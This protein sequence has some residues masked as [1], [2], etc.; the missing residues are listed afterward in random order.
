MSKI[1]PSLKFT[2][3]SAFCESERAGKGRNGKEKKCLQTLTLA[4][5]CKV[6][7]LI[8]SASTISVT[9]LSHFTSFLEAF[10]VISSGLLFG[11]NWLIL[12]ALLAP[13]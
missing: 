5:G 10:R 12:S 9:R 3:I 1:F 4:E 13:L 7:Q 6:M 11:Q 2:K 8:R